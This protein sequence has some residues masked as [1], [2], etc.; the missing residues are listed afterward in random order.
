MYRIKLRLF[1]KSG[2][3]EGRRRRL[4]SIPEK[5]KTFLNGRIFFF[6]LSA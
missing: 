4:K 1:V 6:S 2:I 3:F 5:L